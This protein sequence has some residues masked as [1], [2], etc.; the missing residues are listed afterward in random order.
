MREDIRTFLMPDNPPPFFAEMIGIS[1][2]DGTYF[3]HRSH[4]D[5]CVVEYIVKGTGTVIVNGK[6]YTASAGDVY[7]LEPETD[8]T[9]YSDGEEPWTKLFINAKGALIVPLLKAYGLQGKVLFPR[10]PLEVLFRE[11]FELSRSETDVQLMEHCAL[12]FHEILIGIEDS[13]HKT[14]D[15]SDEATR[16]KNKIDTHLDA[17][18]SI[19]ELADS[20]YR[21][22]DYVIKL[23]KHHYGQTPHAYAIRRKMMTAQKL[24]AETRMPVGEI[25]SSLGFSDQHYF[26]HVF[27]RYV[28]SSPTKFR[29][30]YLMDTAC[31]FARE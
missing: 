27:R 18:F 1:Y 2:C 3:I 8:H 17:M 6:S 7:L 24:L 25:A 28:R 20:I 4:S 31:S 14:A 10:C 30:R 9:Y 19:D 21:S 29:R 5:I 15:L 22:P 26:S 11:L 12:K 16:L 13:L 23:F